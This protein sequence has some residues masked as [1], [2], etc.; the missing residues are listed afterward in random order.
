MMS[1]R[2]SRRQYPTRESIAPDP[3]VGT[4]AVSRPGHTSRFRSAAV[5]LTKINCP[6]CGAGLKSQT[7]FEAGQTVVCP[8]CKNRFEVPGPDEEPPQRKKVRATADDE[9]DERPRKKV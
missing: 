5:A 6:E 2:A 8:K 3:P 1:R 4:L 7:A 9:D